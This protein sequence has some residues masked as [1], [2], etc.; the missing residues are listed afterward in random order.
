MMQSGTARCQRQKEIVRSNP[1]LDV[2]WRRDE[3]GHPAL[4]HACSDGHDSV[5]SILL[6]HP[7]IIELYWRNSFMKACFYGH[8]S[9]VRLLLEDSRLHNPNEPDNAGYT[10][11]RGAA[12]SG[13]LGI[14]KWW[15]TSGKEVNLGQPGHWRTDA[16]KVTK[17]RGTTKVATL[18][19]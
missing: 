3:C 9:C 13:N 4:N 14:I 16:I 6:A 12:C 19:E 7:D 2:N 11:L 18:L 10:P 17:E 1:N 5:V 8:T 15:I